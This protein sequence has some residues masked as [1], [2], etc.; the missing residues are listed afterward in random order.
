MIKS[1]VISIN[2]DSITI[3]SRGVITGEIYIK[4]GEYCFPDPK[5][6]DFIVV[7]LGWWVQTLKKVQLCQIGES[8]EFLFM[9]GPYKVQV[10]K[11]ESNVL[12]L[13]F[14]R[15]N[16]KNSETIFEAKCSSDDLI[17]S[18]INASKD[19]LHVINNNSWD[20]KEIKELERSIKIF[21]E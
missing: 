9:D 19:V 16:I 13:K 18:I 14:L 21:I 4:I 10:L 6:N 2:K 8:N 12:E 1:I 5:W 15:R 20:T 11:I 17:T 3:D 7:I